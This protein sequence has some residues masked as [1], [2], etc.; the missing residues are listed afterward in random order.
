MP[1]LSCHDCGDDLR[2]P[3]GQ[4]G[5]YGVV[6]VRRAEY[7]VC[8]RCAADVRLDQVDAYGE[9]VAVRGALHI[10]RFLEGSLMAQPPL[11]PPPSRTSP[12]AR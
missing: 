7:F 12:A 5:P 8:P 9:A 1:L 4:L 10:S 3:G 6:L 2:V 11:P